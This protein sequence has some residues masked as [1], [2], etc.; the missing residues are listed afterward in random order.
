MPNL[1][2]IYPVTPKC[3]W[4]KVMTADATASKNHDG[5]A[6]GMITLFEAG[7][8]GSKIDQ[9]VSR[10]LGTNIATV[11]R[12]FINN[13]Q[14]NLVA[15]NNT[16]I[17]E[18]TIPA[19]T[20]SETAG[21]IDYDLTRTKGTIDVAPIIPYLPAGY[22]IMAIVGTTIAAGLQVTVWGGDY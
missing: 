18:I 17:Y 20:I 11:L 2:P 22:K 16:L 19:T 3:S 10:A 9:I 15:D 12:L 14:D 8:N 6:A 5:T 1:D 21:L 7:L 4:G 13:G